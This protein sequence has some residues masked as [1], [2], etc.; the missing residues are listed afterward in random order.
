[1]AIAVRFYDYKATE[2]RHRDNDS[3]FAWQIQDVASE[4]KE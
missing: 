3:L 1:M 2:P 4:L